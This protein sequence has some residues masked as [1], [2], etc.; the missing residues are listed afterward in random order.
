MSVPVDAAHRPPGGTARGVALSVTATTLFASLYFYA[1]LL[2]PLTGTEIFGWRMLLTLPCVTVFLMAT[3][4]WSRVVDIARRVRHKPSLLFALMASS[5]LLG[6]QLW[7]F[8][9][10]RGQLILMGTVGV[11]TT[12]SHRSPTTAA[13][14]RRA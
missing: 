6:V 5:A 12:T 14:S 1:T 7:L 10:A 2:R 9:W 3:G 13:T 11:A 8:L 4:H